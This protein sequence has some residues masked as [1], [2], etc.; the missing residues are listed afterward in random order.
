MYWGVLGRTECIW[1]YW[2]GLSVLGSTGE[3]LV[4]WGVL[5]TTEC[6]GEYWGGT[7]VFGST[8]EE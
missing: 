3:D 4:Y 6:I 8:G 5:G 2:G 7:S 1:E